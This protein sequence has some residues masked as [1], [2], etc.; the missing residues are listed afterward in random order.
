VRAFPFRRRLIS[1]ALI[2]L[3]VTAAGCVHVFWRTVPVQVEKFSSDSTRQIRTPIKAHLADGSTVVF[4]DGALIDRRSIRGYGVTYPLMSPAS[5][6]RGDVP[7][8]SVV[9]V[10]TFE[11]KVLVAPTIV[12]SAAASAL[13]LL[14]TAVL[15]VA[16][17]GSCPTLYAATPSGPVL[18]AEGFSYSIAP[19]LEHRDLTPLH[20]RP[21]SDNVIRLELR[22]EALETHFINNIE[23]M[24]VTHPTNAVAISDQ[25]GR[26]VVVAGAHPFAIARDRSGRNVL[27]ALSVSDG[28]V[29]SSLPATI[30]AAKVGDLDDWIDLDARDLAPGDSVVVVLRLRNSLLNT[31][32]LYDGILNGRDA[33]DWVEGGLQQISTAVNLAKWYRTTMGMRVSVDGVA[34]A[35]RAE[36]WNARLG[37]VGPIAFRDIALVLPRPRR[38]AREMHIRLRFV[39]DDWRIDYAAVASSIVRPTPKII[40]VKRA[41]ARAQGAASV[42]NDTAAVSA[43]LEPDGKYLETLPGQRMTLEFDAVA[44]TKDAALTTTYLINWQGYYREWI[45]GR[46]LAEPERTTP[47][48]PGDEAVLTALH[49]WRSRHDALEHSFYSTQVPVK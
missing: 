6:T 43:L 40:P 24:A 27:R 46:W 2:G 14:G 4:R 39:A 12:V 48:V 42:T 38:D 23:L 30:D 21:D 13:A 1:L 15:L 28:D 20:L 34:P 16:I 36:P 7:L 37:D 19:L 41:L 26:P 3:A 9:G 29:F 10:E 25:D 45:R 17:F 47:W 33:P 31:V 11:G 35:S 5:T 18:Q 8:D 44:P 49:S 32:L 22:N